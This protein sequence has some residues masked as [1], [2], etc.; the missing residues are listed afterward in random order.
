MAAVEDGSSALCSFGDRGRPYPVQSF[1]IIWRNPLHIEP[2][3]GTVG[4]GDLHIALFLRSLAGGGA[5]R[6]MANLAAALAARGPRVDVVLGRAEGPFLAELPSAVRVVDLKVRS[7]LQAVESLAAR[8]SDLAALLPVLL[9]SGAPWVLGAIPALIRYLRTERPTALMSALDYGNIAAICAVGAAGTGTPLVI[10]QRC[11]F[12]ADVRNARKARVRRLPPLVRHFYPRADHIVTVSD[13]VADDLSRATGIARD[14]MTTVYNPVVTADLA[15]RAAQDPRHDWFRPGQ[16]PVILGVGK[17]KPQKDFATLLRAF[18]RVRRARPARLVILGEG[19]ERDRLEDLAHDLYVEDDVHLP[20][21]VSN[22]FPYMARAGVFVLSSRFE[23][24]PGVLIQAMACGCPVVSTDCPS[25]PAEILEDGW[26]GP[27]VPV[28]DDEALARAILAVL[29]RL[30]DREGLR[31]RAKFFTSDRAA[32]KV[33]AL[34][35][36]LGGVETA[37]A[38]A[39]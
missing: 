13:G 15:A 36:S 4:D 3:P 37:P 31:K 2:A 24:L 18:A 8:P 9:G 5:E 10:S 19:P 16:P 39:A 21:F 12:T 35:E 25:G 38:R 34:F 11:H 28:G 7:A 29:D 17:L 30:P 1:L 20:G 26:R 14:R 32:Q 22:P 33:I 6:S 27:L 23:G